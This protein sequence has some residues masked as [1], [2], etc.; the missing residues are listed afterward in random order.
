MN[1]QTKQG[2][3]PDLAEYSEIAKLTRRAEG[4]A[5]TV[6]IAMRESA[7]YL[8]ALRYAAL[9][10]QQGAFDRLDAV[11]SPYLPDAHDPQVLDDPLSALLSAIRDGTPEEIRVK[12]VLDAELA[13]WERV[14]AS[15]TDD[16]HTVAL[17]EANAARKVLTG[18]RTTLVGE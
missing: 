8:N 18:L 16:G 9:C 15:A 10:H 4:V 3:P 6:L 11:L 5:D 7:T 1:D 12:M 2:D 17:A 13:E 14:A